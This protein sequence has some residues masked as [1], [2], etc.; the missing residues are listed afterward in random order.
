MDH[1]HWQSLLVKSSVILRHSLT[2]LGHLGRCNT[3]RI[4]S[5]YVVPPKVVKASTVTC[6]CCQRF[7][8]QM[9]PSPALSHN[10]RQCKQSFK[11]MLPPPWKR[12][13]F[14]FVRVFFHR[15]VLALIGCEGATMF[16]GQCY[17]TLFLRNL[18]IFVI[19]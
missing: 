1:L 12:I 19:S 13:F 14:E 6:R 10:L 11:E 9:S 5:I 16:W 2:S 15:Q 8:L 7:R 4:I 18:R 17:K 3:D